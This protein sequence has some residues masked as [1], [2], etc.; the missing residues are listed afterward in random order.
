MLIATGIFPP[1]IGGPASSVPKIASALIKQGVHTDVLTFSNNKYKNEY[2][3]RVVR[4]IRSSIPFWHT[5]KFFFFIIALGKNCDVIFAQCPLAVGL[6][7]IIANFLLRKKLI[8]K[9]VGDEAW[10][11]AVRQKLYIDTLDS[12]VNAQHT[13]LKILF[14]RF[15]QKSILLRFPKIIVPSFYLKSIIA[16]YIGQKN[17]DKVKVINNSFDVI[18]FKIVDAVKEK[19]RLGIQ[20]KAFL[21]V[22]R[23]VPWKN[24]DKLIRA[25]AHLDSSI[26]LFVA[27]DGPEE[28]NYRMLA[29]KLNIA[30]RIIFLGKIPKNKLYEIY[31]I[32]DCFALVSTYEGQSHTLLEAMYMG[33]PVVVSHFGGNPETIANYEKNEIINNPN[34]ITE[35][36][37]KLNNILRIGKNP[38]RDTS[39]RNLFSYEKMLSQTLSLIL[40]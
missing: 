24:V 37:K 18:D 27:G 11:I 2:P 10:E 40:E 39:I 13:S 26:V 19:R 20:G 21:T 25:C 32:V 16:T 12:F 14:L 36:V 38:I 1:D 17:V 33:L 23:L 15:L 4:V 31:Q 5:I 35:L 22:A 30:E 8:L 6:P 28:K 34:D 3:Y 7:A 29:K 9:F